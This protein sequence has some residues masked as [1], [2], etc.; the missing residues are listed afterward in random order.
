MLTRRRLTSHSLSS[1]TVSFGDPKAL[2]EKFVHK[3]IE[4]QQKIYQ[5]NNNNNN[6][7]NILYQHSSQ[8]SPC[9]NVSDDIDDIDNSVVSI[10]QNTTTTSHSKL[11]KHTEA[12]GLIQKTSEH[13]KKGKTNLRKGLK[14]K[15]N[16]NSSLLV[17]SQ[18]MQNFSS[19]KLGTNRI[20]IRE[21]VKPGIFNKG[22]AS[23]KIVARGVPDLVFSEIDFLNSVPSNKRKY[24]KRDKSDSF[25]RRVRSGNSKIE[26]PTSRDDH[27]DQTS[28]IEEILNPINDLEEGNN[29]LPYECDDKTTSSLD[30]SCRENDSS[31]DQ[32][33]SLRENLSEFISKYW[34]L[35]KPDDDEL[36]KNIISD[37]KPDDHELGQNIIVEDEPEEEEE[38]EELAQNIMVV[39]N[40]TII[41]ENT[42]LNDD[43]YDDDD[44]DGDD[45]DD[46]DDDDVTITNITN[47]E[48][49][50]KVMNEVEITLENAI[51]E[52]DD[53]T[54]L[55]E[56]DEKVMDENSV[57]FEDDDSDPTVLNVYQNYNNPIHFVWR[58]HRLH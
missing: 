51:L 9:S 21:K 33:D 23:E 5:N 3:F 43:N 48:D 13:M 17:S 49:G 27:A 1:H 45:G 24:D 8:N 11:Q 50:V 15:R 12:S 42:I 31:S 55:N 46:G 22:K 19:N 56:K 38:E 20:T 6:N 7:N 4:E 34:P 39:D 32:F 30:D 58:R 52:E 28:P 44:D 16:R 37:D 2:N 36:E 18:I 14:K 29:G 57:T 41:N 47:E 26:D 53:I 54:I 10:K 25:S 35:K 40:S